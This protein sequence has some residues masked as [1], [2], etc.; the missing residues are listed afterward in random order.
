MKITIM[1]VGSFTV[2]FGLYNVYHFLYKLQKYRVWVN[3][4]IYVAAILCLALNMAFAMI[5]PL[6]NYCTLSWFFTSYA[7]AYCD[8]IVGICQAYLLSMLKNKL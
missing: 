6:E 7:A 4:A 8:L 2:L 1:L 5:C 3:T